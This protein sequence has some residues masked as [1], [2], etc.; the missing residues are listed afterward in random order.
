M[1][2]IVGWL[3]TE[4][5]PNSCAGCAEHC[6]FWLFSLFGLGGPWFAMYEDFPFDG[7][8]TGALMFGCVDLPMSYFQFLRDQFVL[9]RVRLVKTV[10]IFILRGLTETHT[11]DGSRN[12]LTLVGI[13][14]AIFV[15]LH[16]VAIL[17]ERVFNYQ[18]VV[19]IF[20]KTVSRT[21]LFSVPQVSRA[22]LRC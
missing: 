3:K 5:L 22:L 18:L 16:L 20:A 17:I 8:A 12:L 1:P 15:V 10:L 14:T 9:F 11:P 4:G 13:A 21:R 2:W 6:V 19:R 7:A